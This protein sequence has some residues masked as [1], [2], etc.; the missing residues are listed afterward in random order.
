MPPAIGGTM[1]RNASR[2]IATVSG[3][4]DRRAVITATIIPARHALPGF[5]WT[6]VPAIPNDR[7]PGG[8]ATRSARARTLPPEKT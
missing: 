8:G 6:S 1:R 7:R 3:I 2:P 4:G 5:G